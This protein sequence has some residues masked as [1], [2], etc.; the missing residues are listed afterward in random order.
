MSCDDRDCRVVESTTLA[1]CDNEKHDPHWPTIKVPLVLAEREVQVNVEA[2]ISLDEPALE[3]KRIKKKVFLEQCK[4]VPTDFHGKWVTRAKLYL[5][6]FIRKNIEYATADRSPTDTAVCG[7]ILHTTAHVPFQCVTEIKFGKVKP[8]LISER[9][10]E[11]EFLGKDEMSPRLDKTLF[12]HDVFF[13]EQPFCELVKVRFHELDLGEDFDYDDDL[14]RREKTFRKLREKIVVHVTVKVLQKQQVPLP[15]G[16]K[17]DDDDCKD[18]K[19]HDDHKD[20]RKDYGKD[21][22]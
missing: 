10:E 2:L 5:R 18:H 22:K 13:N 14:P 15:L 7:R 17:D 6:G 16:H 21:Y 20:Y 8:E 12:S 3:I 19:D 11:F 4:L 1:E 9:V